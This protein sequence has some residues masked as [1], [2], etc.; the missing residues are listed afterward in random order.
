YRLCEKNKGELARGLLARFRSDQ[1]RVITRPTVW[2][3]T[4]LS[5]AFHPD[6]L[7]DGRARE[8]LFDTLRRDASRSPV[9]AA[10]AEQERADLWRNNI[11]LFSTSADSEVLR[12]SEG[13]PV[14]GLTLE[15]G[16]VRL[17]RRLGRLG[18]ADLA[19]QQWLITMALSTT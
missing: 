15:P 6:V 13:T 3:S 16:I 9:L 5:M 14:P 7:R 1:V 12:D 8:K 11:P 2:Y 17:R 19:R 18:P 10:C 4:M